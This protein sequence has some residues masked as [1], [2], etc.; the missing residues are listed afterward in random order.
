MY[1]N[2]ESR[3]PEAELVWLILSQFNLPSSFRFCPLPSQFSFCG[4]LESWQKSGVPSLEASL[5]YPS[6]GTATRVEVS[7]LLCSTVPWQDFESSSC[8]RHRALNSIDMH[9]RTV[10]QFCASHLVH[11]IAAW[12]CSLGKLC[13][14]CRL[15]TFAKLPLLFHVC[16]CL[17][18]QA[19]REIA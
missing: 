5:R 11:Q 18:S 6:L 3:A 19:T 14:L 2:V 15:S 16:S 1:V 7:V 12:R 13:G 4:S 8:K 10:F 9:R 17:Q